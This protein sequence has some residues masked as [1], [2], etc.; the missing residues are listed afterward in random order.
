MQSYPLDIMGHDISNMNQAIMGYR[1]PMAS[2]MIKD[3]SG[4][5]EY[6]ARSI[7]LVKN[8][9]RLV[10]RMSK[11]SRRSTRERSRLKR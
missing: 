5:K 8:S 1:R 2:D 10:E 7:E 4:E 11:S 3:E 9:S 6:I